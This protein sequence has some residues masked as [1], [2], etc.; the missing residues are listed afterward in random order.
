[1][2]RTF[3]VL[4]ILFAASFV[5]LAQP[6]SAQP[7]ARLLSKPPAEYP[8]EALTGDISGEVAVT[9]EVDVNGK[10]RK[11]LPLGG[12]PL[13]QKSAAKAALKAKFA[14]ATVN[15]RAVNSRASLTYRF[16]LSGR[17]CPSDGSA[18][19]PE[20]VTSKALITFK[21]EPGFTG[22]AR[23]NMTTGKVV[24]RTLFCHTGEVA[25]IEVVSGLPDG[26][27]GRAIV[28]ARQIRFRPATKDGQTVS[29]WVTLTYNFDIY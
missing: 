19:A 17:S 7:E 13:L 23:A 1:M 25:D 22:R 29:Q 27:T 12:H 2:T 15:G 24:L 20:E 5:C 16:D 18:Y 11:A 14:P 4:A 28:A 21:P 3:I 10:V 6:G 8:D 26:L 9:V